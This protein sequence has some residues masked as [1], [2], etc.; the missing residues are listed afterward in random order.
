MSLLFSRC[1]LKINFFLKRFIYLFEKG[2]G[3]GG[4]MRDRGREE[5][6]PCLGQSP[7]QCWGSILGP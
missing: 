3:D 6:T 2:G 1:I 5:Q 4:G 7:T